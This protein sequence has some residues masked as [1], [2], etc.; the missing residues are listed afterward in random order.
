MATDESL[1]RDHEIGGSGTEDVVAFDKYQ[2]QVKS[3]ADLNVLRARK[4]E[5]CAGSLRRF[6]LVVHS[7]EDGLQSVIT[8]SDADVQLVRIDRLATI[9]VDAGL[10]GWLFGKSG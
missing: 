1:W 3:R 7:P 2:V 10:T 5:F 8:P 4:A 9:L 6:Y